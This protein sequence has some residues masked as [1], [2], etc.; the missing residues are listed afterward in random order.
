MLM[1][2]QITLALALNMG[3]VMHAYIGVPT[4]GV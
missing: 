1:S 2:E 3:P 4:Q